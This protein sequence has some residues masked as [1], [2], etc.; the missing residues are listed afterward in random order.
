MAEKQ[1]EM[2]SIIRSFSSYLFFRCAIISVFLLLQFTTPAW[3]SPYFALEPLDTSSPRATME[4]FQRY[5]GAYGKA[6]RSPDR[7]SYTSEAAM[8]RAIGCFDLSEVAPI[9][10]ENVGRESVLL[11]GEILNRIPLPSPGE[12]P[13]RDKVRKEELERWYIPLTGITL[14]RVSEGDRKNDFLFTPETIR[15]LSRYYEEVRHLPAREGALENIYE[16]SQYASGGVLSQSFIDSLPAPARHRHYGLTL[17]QWVGLAVTFVCGTILLWMIWIRYKKL[18]SSRAGEKWPLKVLAYPLLALGVLF[19]ARHFTQYQLNISGTVNNFTLVLL[20][21]LFLLLLSWTVYAVSNI[22]MHAIISADRDK[23]N[24]LNIDFI[25]LLFRV[26]SI[27]IIFAIWYWGG[28]DFG[29]P[30]N[31]VFASAGIAGVAL[32]L[33]ARES[34]AN[35]FGGLSILFDGPFKTGDFI[36]L[37]TGERGEVKSIGMRST[38]LLTLDGVLITIPNSVITNA[39]IVNESAPYQ[40]FRARLAIG[41]AYGSDLEL[42]ETV[43]TDL[44]TKCELVRTDP[45]PVARIR[46]FGDSSIDF[47]LLAWAIRPHDRGRLIHDL[48]KAIDKRFAE[49][50]ITIP[51]PQ[52]DLHMQQEDK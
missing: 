25:N 32:A 9:L 43:L 10:A 21:G 30:V 14:H 2:F 48:S 45:P 15:R 28:L 38:R 11:L 39:K 1:I 22:I 50:G 34:L 26:V 31:A 5:A 52:R 13:D 4:S 17:W 40:H 20:H 24:L 3:S 27:V 33:A 35:F 46:T 29:L 37:D 42:V 49:E 19:V 8:A 51:F 6:L 44:A 7:V 23:E 16:A 12:I 47:E 41:V 36:V 18:R